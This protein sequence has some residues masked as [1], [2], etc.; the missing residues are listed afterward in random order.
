MIHGMGADVVCVDKSDTH[1]YVYDHMDDSDLIDLAYPD[2]GERDKTQIIS[3]LN[4]TMP[5]GARTDT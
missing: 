1:H 4:L 3:A 2:D 5:L